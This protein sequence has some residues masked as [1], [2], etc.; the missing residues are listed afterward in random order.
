VSAVNRIG[1]RDV[2]VVVSLW[3]RIDASHR[4]FRPLANARTPIL[5]D[6]DDEYFV[7]VERTCKNV[8]C[9][10]IRDE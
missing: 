3:G 1:Q 10:W 7:F 2:N 8:C 5:V 9:Y 6:G 4:D